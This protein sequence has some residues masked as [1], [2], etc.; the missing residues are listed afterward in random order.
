[1]I[2]YLVYVV[3]VLLPAYR[4]STIV[5]MKAKHSF[6]DCWCIGLLSSA[7]HHVGWA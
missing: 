6:R 1:V 3:C 5:K 4:G 2:P 7:S